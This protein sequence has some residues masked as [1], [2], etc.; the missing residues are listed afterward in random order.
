M[1]KATCSQEFAWL[2]SNL[3]KTILYHCRLLEKYYLFDFPTHYVI[4][5]GAISPTKYYLRHAVFFSIDL[6]I[7]KTLNGFAFLKSLFINTWGN[8]SKVRTGI[9]EF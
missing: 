5:I 4:A 2:A 1:K 7:E 9:G 8:D 3:M 6:S